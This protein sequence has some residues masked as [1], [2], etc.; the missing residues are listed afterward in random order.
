MVFQIGWLST[1]NLIYFTREV[2]TFTPHL[3][4]VL[5]YAMYDG[6]EEYVN[7]YNT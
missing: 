7:F 3:Q 1:S 6:F 5:V 4:Q 2:L